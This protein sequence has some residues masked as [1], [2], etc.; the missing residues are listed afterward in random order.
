MSL[1]NGRPSVFNGSRGG[2]YDTITFVSSQIYFLQKPG[3]FPG[4]G[5]TNQFVEPRDLQF[6]PAPTSKG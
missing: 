5:F 2:F 4:A 1:S 3:F 6:L